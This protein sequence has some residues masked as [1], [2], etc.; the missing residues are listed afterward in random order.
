MKV[1]RGEGEKNYTA[2]GS[3][4]AAGDSWNEVFADAFLPDPCRGTRQALS[5]WVVPG[6][7]P[8]SSCCSQAR[9]AVEEY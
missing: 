3:Y 5:H 4:V 8:V 2:L 7:D 1:F 9:I 6:N